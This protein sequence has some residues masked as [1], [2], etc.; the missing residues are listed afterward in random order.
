MYCRRCGKEINPKAAMCVHCNSPV[1]ERF[2]PL[3]NNRPPD[4]WTKAM[5]PIG[6][7]GYAIAAGYLGLLSVLGVF[8]PF[9]ILFG[10][11]ALYDIGRH[12]EKSG[13]G[14][15][16]FGI[17]MGTVFTIIWGISCIIIPAMNSK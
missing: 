6:R 13:K 11:M 17:V 5:L 10:V 9:A 3:T 16:V 14:R 15:A 12:P 8:G 2:R 7:S 1:S 4:S